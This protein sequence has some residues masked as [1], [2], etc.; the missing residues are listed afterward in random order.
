MWVDFNNVGT[1]IGGLG[2]TGDN[3]PM[4]GVRYDRILASTAL[5]LFSR[6]PQVLHSRRMT[7]RR[8]LT[9]PCRCRAR[10]PWQ[11]PTAADI[12][13]QP[14]E[15]TGAIPE[16]RAAPV[17]P[18]PAAAAIAP[19][20][21]ASLDPADRPIAEKLHEL[22]AAKVDQ[23]FANKK[24][25]RAVEAFYENR[26]YAPLWIDKGVDNARAGKAIARLK[27]ANADGLDPERL[28]NS[29]LFGTEPGRTA[30]A[31]LRM[32]ATVLTYARHAQAGRFPY[33]RISQ[34]IELPQTPPDTA[35]VLTKI[36]DAKDVAE[37]LDEF[38][39]TNKDYKKLKAKLAELRGKNGGSA[40]RSLTA[41]CS[42]ST[43]RR[44]W[45]IRAFRSCASVSASRATPA[46]SL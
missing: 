7:L 10:R 2:M 5:A 37:A 12:A 36:A 44:R 13:A 26:N 19:D 18:A 46:T 16:R 31:E 28:P 35:D 9:R 43:R 25:R 34:N 30:E 45:K 11:P 40:S 17:A 21:L 42:S 24:E 1:S 33:P 8:R 15:T 32:T 22:L 27:L 6:L 4:R 3:Y 23:I 39:P 14:A 29:G 20:P 41:R 38:S